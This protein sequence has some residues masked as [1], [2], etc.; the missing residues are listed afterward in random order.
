MGEAAGPADGTGGAEA[1]GARGAETLG[2]G[3]G[4]G[5]VELAEGPAS[6]C[7][8]GRAACVLP[9]NDSRSALLA[10]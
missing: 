5:G 6:A 2:A 7:V 8:A 10:A 9:M 3:V 1:E 4:G